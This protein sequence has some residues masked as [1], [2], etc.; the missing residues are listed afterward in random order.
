VKTVNRAKTGVTTWYLWDGTKLLAEYNGSGS[1]IKRYGYLADD[2]AP[3]Q[4]E[5]TSGTYNVHSDHLDTPRLLTD[6]SQQIVWR[7][8]QEAFGK[9]V[10]DAVS[11]VE[12]NV[13]FPGQYYDQETGLYYNYFRYYD[14]RTG[15]YVTSDPIGLDGGLNTYLYVDGNPISNFDYDGLISRKKL[16]DRLNALAHLACDG[17]VSCK[18]T[19]SCFILKAKKIKNQTCLYLRKAVSIC[20]G[21]KNDPKPSGHKIQ[22]KEVQNRIKQCNKL[23]IRNKCCE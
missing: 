10:I 6:A 2:Y 15:R 8:R 4:M 20:H 14:P 13:R 5:D 22:L 16:C 9:T 21:R 7:G 23:I 19:D 17:F 18:G 3:I 12:M 11:T 1:R